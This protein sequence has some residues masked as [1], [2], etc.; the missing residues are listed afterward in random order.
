MTSLPE[1]YEMAARPSAPGTSAWLPAAQ[2]PQGGQDA[3]VDF[4]GGL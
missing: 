2:E 4:L 3:L 1:A